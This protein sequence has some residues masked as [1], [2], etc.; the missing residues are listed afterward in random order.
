MSANAIIRCTLVPL[1]AFGLFVTC[2]GS[3]NAEEIEREHVR[4][5][6]NG[7]SKEYAEAIATTVEAARAICESEFSYDMPKTIRVRVAAEAAGKTR[8]FNDGVDT[9]S[10]TVRQESNLK[11]P[12]T[13]GVFHI[14]GLCHEVAHLAMYRPIKDHSWLS[15]PGAEGWAHYLGS[16]LVDKVYA[17]EGMKLWPD[18]YD[19]RADGTKRLATQ[20]RSAKPSEVARGAQAWQQLVPL[21][22]AKEMPGVFRDWGAAKIDP[23]DPAAALKPVLAKGRD[24]KKLAAWWERHGDLLFVKRAGSGFAAVRA[25][26]EDLTGDAQ[27]FDH[28]DGKAAGKSSIAGSGH[29]VRFEAADAESYLVRVEVFGSRYGAPAAPKENFR[30]WLC[31]KDGKEVASWEFPYEKFSRGEAK[32]VPLQVEPT[33][34]PREFFVFVG[35][36][37]AA[38]KGV[39]VNYDEKASGNSF[40]GLPGGEPAKFDKGDWLIRTHLDRQKGTDPLSGEPPGAKRR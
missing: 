9:F 2:Y 3:A 39:F 4:L 18:K 22:G 21:V 13:S 5:E 7:I 32:W 28:D 16:E 14:Y 29:A 20:L 27:Q 34:V 8:L 40:T 1:L 33:R 15:M 10:L 31:D 25:K 30:V 11:K 23:R 38:T 12:A 35:F 26:P 17:R 36:N 19:Y 24:A 37:P 6:Y